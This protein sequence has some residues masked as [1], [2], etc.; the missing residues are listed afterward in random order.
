MSTGAP[1]RDH[2][3]AVRNRSESLAA[4]VG[5]RKERVDCGEPGIAGSCRVAALLLE[6]FQECQDEWASSRLISIFDGLILRRLA[7]K[8]SRSWKLCA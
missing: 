2:R 3:N 6:M 1:V 5:I 7:A 8:P 4:F